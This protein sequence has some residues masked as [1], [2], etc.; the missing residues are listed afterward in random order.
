MY[1]FVVVAFG[2]IRAIFY[3]TLFFFIAEYFSRQS[4]TGTIDN[5]SLVQAR[6][7]NGRIYFMGK[8]QKMIGSWSKLILDK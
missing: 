3:C 7:E 6:L 4:D 8:K 2:L 1:R 5:V